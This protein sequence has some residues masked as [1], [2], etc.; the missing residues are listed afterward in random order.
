MLYA[1]IKD[2]RNYRIVYLLPANLEDK[3]IDEFINNLEQEVLK[4]GGTMNKTSKNKSY[5]VKTKVNKG[6]KGVY[7]VDNNCTL[8]MDKVT[9]IQR[10]LTLAQG[11][12][13][14]YMFL[15]IEEPKKA[16]TV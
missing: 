6:H 4:N 13:I 9:E 2:M 3:L 1:N 7:L 11:V 14:N 16:Q 10:Y 15:A 8:P 12:V 5:M